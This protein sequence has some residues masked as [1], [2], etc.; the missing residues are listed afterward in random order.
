MQRFLNERK[1]ITYSVIDSDHKSKNPFPLGFVFTIT[2][3]VIRC[4]TSGPLFNPLDAPFGDRQSC[5]QTH[6]AIAVAIFQD[7]RH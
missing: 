6:N 2:I 5:P 3:R 4:L 1:A 7:L